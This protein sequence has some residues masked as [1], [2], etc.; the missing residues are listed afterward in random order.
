L[1]IL[2]FQVSYLLFLLNKLLAQSVLLFHQSRVFL[3]LLLDEIC[4][5]PALLL[6]LNTNLFLLQRFQLQFLV[7]VEDVQDLSIESI[8]SHLLPFQQ[9]LQ[10]IILMLHSLLF[11]DQ[12]LYPRLK[13]EDLLLR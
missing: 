3:S 2:K 7:L 11:G 5:P 8:A 12:L 9:L 10:L 4:I 1:T 6:H 13:A